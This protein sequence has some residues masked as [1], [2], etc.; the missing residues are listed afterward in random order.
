MKVLVLLFGYA[1][2]GGE[3]IEYTNN[4]NGTLGITSRG[5]DGTAVLIHDQGTRVYKYEVSGVSL[6]RINNLHVVPTDSTLGDTR[7]YSTLPLQ[8]IRSDRDTGPS[9]LCFNQQA[10]VG[11][12]QIAFSK[13][14]QFN[15][16]RPSIGSFTPGDAT[17]VTSRVRTVTGTSCDGKRGIIHRYWICRSSYR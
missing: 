11:G 17:S 3:I 6:R 5:V 14:Y 8:I 9:M 15:R 13:N 1:Y 7:G 10:D 12:N 2:L 4:G 16:M